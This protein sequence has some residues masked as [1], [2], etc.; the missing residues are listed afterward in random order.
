[1]LPT[2]HIAVNKG[3]RTITQ[4]HACAHTKHTPTTGTQSDQTPL[5]TF[6][7]IKMSQQFGTTITPHY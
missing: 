5:M 4:T 3:V 6:S 7:C 2:L 1:M